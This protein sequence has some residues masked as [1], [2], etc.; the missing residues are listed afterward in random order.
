M[1]SEERREGRYQRRRARREKRRK[2]RSEKIGGLETAFSYHDLFRYGKRCCNGVR[3]KRS[4]QTFETHLFSGTAIRRRMLVSRTWKP[5]PYVHFTLRERGKARTIDA[6]HVIDRQVHK[7]LVHN[8]LIPLYRPEM[9]YDNGASMKGKGLAFSYRRLKQ[10]LCWHYRRHGTEG[11]VVQ[12][13]MK[14]YFPGAPHDVV[15]DRHERLIRDDDLRE[16]A[17]RVTRSVSGDRGLPLGVEPSQQE[18]VALPSAVDQYIKCGLS[19]RCAGHY[20]DDYYII[21]ETK[22]R[23]KEVLRDVADRFGR[24]GILRARR[25]L[26]LFRREVKAGTRT[27]EEVKEWLKTAISYYKESNDHGRV[28]RMHRLYYAMFEEAV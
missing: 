18:M 14:D 20:M 19:V 6:P 4:C 11:Y 16:V 9:I 28:L 3:W 8:V 23:A 25:K 24:K 7:V 17:D 5:L 2:E 13:D 10:Q 22:E 27:K 1:T 21:V 26:Q 12:L 15:F